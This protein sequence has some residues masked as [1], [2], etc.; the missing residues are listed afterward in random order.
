MQSPL[1]YV[2]ILVSQFPSRIQD[3]SQAEDAVQLYRRVLSSRPDRSVTIASIGIHTNLAALLR[4]PA[5]AHSFLDGRSLVAQKVS[6]LA[7]MGGKY[8]SGLECNLEGG[9]SNLHNH[10]VAAQSSAYVAAHWPPESKIMWSGAEVGV[11]VLTG[12]FEFQR[13]VPAA[14]LNPVRAAMV[15]FTGGPNRAR[16]SWDP[17]TTLAAVRGAGAVGCTECSD[18]DGHNYVDPTTGAN[19]WI[20]GRK[21]NQTYLVLRDATA[22]SMAINALLCQSPKAGRTPQLSPVQLA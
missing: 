17:L 20:T 19:K 9:K 18:C 21:M 6:L 16:F 11:R 12:G 2:N 1:D 13:C 22:A 5:D 8:P 3:S 4:S 10:L 15:N 7:V 14:E